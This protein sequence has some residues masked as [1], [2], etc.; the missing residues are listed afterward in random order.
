MPR[1]RFPHTLDPS[2]T[3]CP[4]CAGAGWV[5]RHSLLNG[6]HSLLQRPCPRCE[7]DGLAARESEADRYGDTDPD[8]APFDGA[9]DDNFNRIFGGL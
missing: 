1:D 8:P 2:E 9:F 5:S 3:T 4:D 6:R 7:G